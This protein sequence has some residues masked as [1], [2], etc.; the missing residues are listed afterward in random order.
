[1]PLSEGFRMEFP[2]WDTLK[3]QPLGGAPTERPR[4]EG[5]RR[6]PQRR[7]TVF[8]RGLR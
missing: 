6:D 2:L 5:S 4:E 3:P 1:M 7:V 8:V